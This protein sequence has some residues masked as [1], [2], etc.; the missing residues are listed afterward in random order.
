MKYKRP[1]SLD[2]LY[3]LV[4][5]ALEKVVRG[6][7]V[8]SVEKPT[9][10][11]AL[12]QSYML[13]VLTRL[14][15]GYEPHHELII[16]KLKRHEEPTPPSN[17]YRQV[18]ASLVKKLKNPHLSFSFE[19]SRSS[20][21][22]TR[23]YLLHVLNPISMGH[24]PR[25]ELIM[26]S[27][28]EYRSPKQPLFDINQIKEHEQSI[29]SDAVQVW[30]REVTPYIQNMVHLML[31]KATDIEKGTDDAHEWIEAIHY[32][33]QGENDKPVLQ[34]E[35]IENDCAQAR[36]ALLWQVPSHQLIP[37]S[38]LVPGFDYANQLIGEFRQVRNQCAM[39]ESRKQTQQHTTMKMSF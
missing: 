10:T 24:E 18:E 26:Q 21:G 36:N 14:A 17:L 4:D 15:Q 33:R 34:E 37:D 5:T 32:L 16:Q 2:D 39:I 20:M 11:M 31:Y 8:S 6:P 27:L 28:S 7:N 23:S 22:L 25:H 38:L 35:R 3:K 19:K 29:L 30:P 9:K 1:K 13:H 12:T